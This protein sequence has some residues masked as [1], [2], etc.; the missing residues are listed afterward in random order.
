MKI[1]LL[2][3]L[4]LTASLFATA[5]NV[6]PPVGNVGIGTG[7]SAPSA[8]LH[9][10]GGNI[11]NTNPP[12]YPYGMNI[13][14]NFTGPWS[15]EF[16]LSYN[17]TGK[18]ASFGVM[19]NSG[20]LTYAYIGGNTANDVATGSPWMVFNNVGNIGIGTTTPQ[21]KLDV[22]GALTL[23]VWANPS[24]FTG[25]GDTE[26]NRYLLLLNSNLKASASGLKA[27]GILVSD[28]YAYANPGKNDLVVK[29]NVAIGTTT[30]GT[31]KL[32][33]EGTIGARRIKVQQS[34]WADYV[35]HEGYQLPSLQKIE[36]FIKCNKHLPDIPSEAEVVKDGIDLGEMNKLLLQKIEE[37]TLH[38]IDVNK[39]LGDLKKRMTTMEISSVKA[40]N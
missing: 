39:Q 29:G 1:V 2:Q 33:V 14:V 7:T 17:A 27:G 40:S 30:T 3:A 23:E 19:G 18:L 5:Q 6:F 34:A 16:S 12:G 22:R 31:N 8:L 10:N 20:A 13:D 25:T 37:L 38:L 26:L 4:L 28:T 11:K 32:A 24:I 9:V 15:R 35:F 36:Q 21:T